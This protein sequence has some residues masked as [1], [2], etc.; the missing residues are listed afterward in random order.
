MALSLTRMENL[1]AVNQGNEPKLRASDELFAKAF[2]ANPHPMSL[3][4]LEEG[5]ILEVN[6]S[7][8]ELTGYTRPELIGQMSIESVWEMPLS[9]S[10]LIRQIRE[11]GVVRNLEARLRTRNRYSRLV[12]LSTLMVEIDDQWCLLSVSNDITELRRAEEEVRL[13]QAISMDVSAAPDLDSA[14]KVVL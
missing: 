11:Q 8:V 10:E 12:L 5:R 9:R 14:L 1:L 7:F 13:L 4:T 2:N 3:A 6:E